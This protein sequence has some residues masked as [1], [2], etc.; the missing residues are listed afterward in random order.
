MFSMTLVHKA[1][2]VA[3]GLKGEY[4][5]RYIQVDAN[6]SYSMSGAALGYTPSNTCL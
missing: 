6:H 2:F 1:S 4:E 5:A 3:A